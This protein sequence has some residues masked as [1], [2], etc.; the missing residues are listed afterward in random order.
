MS[1]IRHILSISGGKD[2][3]A[4]AFYLRDTKPDI[5]FEYVFFDTGEEL[6]ETYDYLENLENLEK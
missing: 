1:T 5:N 2:S 4:L 3:A 6:Q